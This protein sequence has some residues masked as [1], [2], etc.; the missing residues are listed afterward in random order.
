MNIC[1][2]T[3]ERYI[4]F[5]I[6]EAQKSNVGSRHG[7]VAVASGKIIARGCNSDRTISRDGLIGNMCSCHAEIDVLRKCLKRKLSKKISL[8]IV[9]ITLDNRITSSMPCVECYKQMNKFSIRT[10]IYSDY[11]GRLIKIPMNQFKTIHV[12]SGSK[13]LQNNRVTPLFK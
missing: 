1:S 4:N 7:C 3:D 8:Y 13:A 11:S 10:I 12:S 9:R 2:N 5:A 6:E